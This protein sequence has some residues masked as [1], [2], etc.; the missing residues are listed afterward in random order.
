MNTLTKNQ[1]E[2]VKTHSACAD[3]GGVT[4][5]IVVAWLCDRVLALNTALEQAQG[6]K[7]SSPLIHVHRQY[8][9][10]THARI[11]RLTSELEQA[12]AR[13]A[14]LKTAIINCYRDGK[15]RPPDCHCVMINICSLYADEKKKETGGENG[16]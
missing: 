9:S 5:P 2:G 3:K 6:G 7:V 4:T 1:L 10:E 12:Q 16:L 8:L 13:D 14:Y 15:I 11:D